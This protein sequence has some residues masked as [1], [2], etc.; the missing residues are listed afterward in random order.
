M[1]LILKTV[2]N[3]V[4]AVTNTTGAGIWQKL[5]FDTLPV[6]VDELEAEADN[7]Q[8]EKVI[9]LAR[10]AASGGAIL[11]GGSDHQGME[12]HAKSC[13]L[14]SSILHPPLPPQD[15]N[16]MAILSLNPIP[17]KRRA[18]DLDLPRLRRIGQSLMERFHRHFKVFP[19]I[20]A[21]FVDGLIEVGHGGRTAD[22]FGTLLAC[23][24]IAQYDEIPTGEQ[25]SKWVNELSVDILHQNDDQMDDARSCLHHLLTTEIAPWSG[26]T[27][28]V[29]SEVIYAAV[30]EIK[31]TDM[32]NNN[33]K[34]LE[35]YGMK[36]IVAGETKGRGDEPVE[37]ILLVSNQH[38]T[39]GE[40]FKGTQ[41]QGRSDG[42]G[43]WTQSLRRLDKAQAWAPVRIMGVAQRSTA[44]FIE[45]II[46]FKGKP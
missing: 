32:D 21:A 44:L 14:F 7:R 25:V 3:D 12:F 11:R 35:R 17:A 5:G 34:A 16:R 27:Q 29:I 23:S 31:R 46:D 20:L 36:I 33:C 40:L 1:Q 37:F 38:R 19:E 2:L 39:L 41:W 22:V 10:E 30:D 8:A 18:P 13:F 4:I 15:K 45:D 42:P 6:M 24:H 43:V 26:G 28:K 9:K